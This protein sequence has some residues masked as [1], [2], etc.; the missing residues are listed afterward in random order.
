MD[1]KRPSHIT[2][3][4]ERDAARLRYLQWIA[5]HEGNSLPDRK[6]HSSAPKK[7]TSKLMKLAALD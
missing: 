7:G 5:R 6:E 2:N 1:A 3:Y 4:P